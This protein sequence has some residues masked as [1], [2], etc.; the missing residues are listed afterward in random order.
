[1]SDWYDTGLELLHQSII[2]N[3]GVAADDIEKVYSFLVNIG[4]IDY[5]VEKEYIWEEF[6]CHGDDDE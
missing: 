4:L 1:M 5:D 6:T 3:T 2:D